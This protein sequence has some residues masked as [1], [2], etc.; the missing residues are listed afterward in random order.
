MF[1]EKPFR[2]I[3]RGELFTLL[4]H[5]VSVKLDD[6]TALDLLSGQMYPLNFNKKVSHPG[7]FT[8]SQRLFIAEYKGNPVIVQPVRVGFE[9]HR[10]LTLKTEYCRDA[11]ELQ[12]I[13]YGADKSVDINLTTIRAYLQKSLI[14]LEALSIQ[15]ERQL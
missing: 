6:K 15:R 12:G 10:F 14:L 5:G 8:F 7:S 2:L 1:G 9:L 3:N 4:G 11:Q 13:P